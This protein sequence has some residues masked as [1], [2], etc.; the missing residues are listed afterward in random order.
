[1]LSILSGESCFQ[2]FP[3]NDGARIRPTIKSG[4]LQDS[5]DWL[6]SENHAG[7]GI[8]FAVNG[9]RHG[10]RGKEHVTEVRTYYA[11]VD[12]STSDSRVKRAKALDLLS[13]DAI[14]SAI[15]ESKNGLHAY[16]FATPGHPLDSEEYKRVNLGIIKAVGGDENAKDIARVL[17]IPGFLHYKNPNDPFPVE[18][19]FHDPDINYTR[20]ELLLAFPSP[21]PRRAP[22]FIPMHTGGSGFDEWRELLSE[23][24]GWQ[25]SPGQRHSTLLVM[26]GNAYRLGIP[27]TQAIQDLTPIIENW[28][29]TPGTARTEAIGAVTYAYQSGQPFGKGAVKAVTERN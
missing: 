5:L 10:K 7:A 28:G 23:Y 25:G 21:K 9:M 18:I 20:Q 2:T 15:V 26:A 27:Q 12:L 22:V 14:P 13:L 8:F 3:D 11:D 1:M 4:N 6:K 29:R 24:A 17:R 16:W 19:L